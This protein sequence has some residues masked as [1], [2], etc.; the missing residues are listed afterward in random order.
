MRKVIAW[1]MLRLCLK[2]NDEYF[3][4]SSEARKIL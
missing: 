2:L 1:M 4:V 3:L